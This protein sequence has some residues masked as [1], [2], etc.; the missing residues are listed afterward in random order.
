MKLL[1]I[2]SSARIEG[3]IT[4]QIGSYLAAG[5][6]GELAL[7]DLGSQPLS[8]MASEDLIDLHSSQQSS[9][10]SLQSHFE[11]SQRLIE[12]LNAADTLILEAPMYNFAV[13]VVLKQWIDAIC[14]AGHTFRYTPDGPEGLVT[15]ARAVIVTASGGA[16]LGTGYDFVGPYLEQMCRFIGIG[17]IHHLRASGSKGAPQQLLAA[18]FAE[19]DQLLTELSN[20]TSAEE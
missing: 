10:Q 7:R 3:S 17:E 15:T 4:R 8:A 13:P 6:G 1:K 5:L 19:V 2:S 9:R 12:E 18:A 14:R 16:P 20:S 11:Q